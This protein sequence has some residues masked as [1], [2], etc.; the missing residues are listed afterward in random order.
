VGRAC[1][2][3]P[4]LAEHPPSF[5]WAADIPPMEIPPGYPIVETVLGAGAEV[6]EQSRLA[7]LDSWYDGAT[8]TSAGTPSVAFGPRSI[9]GAH[10][11]DES[12]PVDDLVRCA[13]AIALAA[14]R[15][16]GTA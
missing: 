16:C 3:D 5:E 4:W 1:A 6:G 15:F 8:Y 2:A 14:L 10:T 11:I 13:Q 9:T 7:G 12:V